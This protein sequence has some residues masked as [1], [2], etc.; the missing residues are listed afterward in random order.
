M[1]LQLLFLPIDVSA[2]A[3]GSQRLAGR[4]PEVR[5]REHTDSESSADPAVVVKMEEPKEVQSQ[6]FY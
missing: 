2:F 6:G 5:S 4:K 3:S 1:R